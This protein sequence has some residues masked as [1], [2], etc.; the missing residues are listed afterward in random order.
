MTVKLSPCESPVVSQ[1]SQQQSE[2]IQSTDIK[3]AKVIFTGNDTSNILWLGKYKG[4][5]LSLWKRDYSFPNVPYKILTTKNIDV[6]PSDVCSISANKVCVS[7][8]DGHLD[9][10]NTATDDIALLKKIS[11][12]HDECESRKICV[13]ENSIIS[14]STNGSLV[15]VDVETGSSSTI[16]SGQACIRS[17]CQATGSKLVVTGTS[18]GQ[19]SVWDL[20]DKNSEVEIIEPLKHLLPSKKSLDAVSALAEHPAQTNLISCGTDDGLVGAVDLR[21]GENAFISSTYLVFNKGVTQVMFPKGNS[22]S[23]VCSSNDGSIIRLDASRIPM[24]G[25]NR[26][27]KDNVWLCSDQ[28]AENLR[29]NPIRSENVYPIS[30]FDCRDDTIVASSEIGFISLFENLPFLPKASLF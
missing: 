11:S 13:F 16:S 7:Y 6:N 17:L 21:N 1:F 27:S 8:C 3:V 9:I 28:I 18:T 15:L 23:L 22:E 20:R 24:V 12:V 14:A 19:I 29:V 4:R 2:A 30:S 25:T 5:C 10:L 26:V